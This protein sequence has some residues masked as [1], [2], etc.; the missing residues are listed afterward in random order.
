[1]YKSPINSGGFS[2]STGD[3]RMSE[4]STV[5]TLSEKGQG[6]TRVDVL[7]PQHEV[8]WEGVEGNRQLSFLALSGQWKTFLAN[9][10]FT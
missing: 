3:R 2:I 9:T 7:H 1:M 5:S 6:L 8:R 10:K 4:P